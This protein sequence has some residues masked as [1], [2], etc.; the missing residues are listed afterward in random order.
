M[1][2]GIYRLKDSGNKYIMQPMI[3]RSFTGFGVEF[4]FAFTHKVR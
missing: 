3:T 2:T 4:N 1:R